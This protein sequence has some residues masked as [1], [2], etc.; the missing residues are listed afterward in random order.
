MIQVDAPRGT[1]PPPQLLEQA[2][3]EFCQV[4][5]EWVLVTYAPNIPDKW[6]LV[7]QHQDDCPVRAWKS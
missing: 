2:R 1:L 3:D 6:R 5:R 7:A 4:C